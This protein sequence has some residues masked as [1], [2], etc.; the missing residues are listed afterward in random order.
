M[1]ADP[2]ANTAVPTLSGSATEGSTLTLD[3]GTWTGTSPLAYDIVVAA[4]RRRRRQLRRIPGESGSTYTLTDRRPRRHGPR[5]R[6]R[7]EHRRR[8]RRRAA[9]TAVVAMDPPANTVLPA[10]SGD[11]VDGET[12]TAARHLDR[13][14]AAAPHLPVAALRRAR[15]QLRRHRRRHEHD[16]HLTGADI[17]HVVRVEVT[18]ANDAGTASAEST[19]GGPVAPAPPVNVTS[20]RPPAPPDG[21]VLT[22]TTAAGPA[23]RR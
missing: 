1:V 18:A 3:N 9:P 10:V 12:L 4:L 20:R 19:R 22:A 17:G 23:R 5:A 8:R 15:R 13:H 14:A 2:P 21:E 11:R 7:L 6:H 16:L